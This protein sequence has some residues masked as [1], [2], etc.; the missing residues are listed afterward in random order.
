M[1]YGTATNMPNQGDNDT[2]QALLMD[3]A[4]AHT[5]ASTNLG[6]SVLQL[7]RGYGKE[8]L[9]SYIRTYHGHYC[10]PP[11]RPAT[12]AIFPC[13]YGHPEKSFNVSTDPGAS[14]T[15]SKAG[16]AVTQYGLCHRDFKGTVVLMSTSSPA[17]SLP[18]DL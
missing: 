7:D 15:G 3:I 5:P 12:V 11:P 1:V 8:G 17:I 9:K 18:Q 6:G 14:F 2:V 10:G 13:T 16:A 4:G